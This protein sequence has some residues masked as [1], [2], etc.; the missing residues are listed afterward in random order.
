MQHLSWSCISKLGQISCVKHNI[1]DQQTLTICSSVWV[2]SS[3]E[4]V[5]KIQLI[6]NFAARLITGSH[7]YDHITLTLKELHV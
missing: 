4:N 1:F 5:K 2:N 7:K 6:Q 3:D